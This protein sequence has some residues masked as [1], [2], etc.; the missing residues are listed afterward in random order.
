MY[1]AIG[2]LITAWLYF[3]K[4][5]NT[6]IAHSLPF[7]RYLQTFLRIGPHSFLLIFHGVGGAWQGSPYASLFQQTFIDRFCLWRRCIRKT[8][9]SS[10]IDRMTGTHSLICLFLIPLS[11]KKFS[12]LLSWQFGHVKCVHDELEPQSSTTWLERFVF[13]WKDR[14]KQLQ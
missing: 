5:K 2:W 12:F 3:W 6:N 4:N 13:T 8:L 7:R 14:P 10:S 1:G 9:F 11:G